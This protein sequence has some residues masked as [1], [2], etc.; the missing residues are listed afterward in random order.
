[1]LSIATGYSVDYLLRQ[2]AAGRENYYTGAVADGEPPGRWWGAGTAALGLS[3]EVDPQDMRAVFERFLDPRDEHFRDPS[4]WGEAATLGHTGRAYT[5]EDELYAQLL[6]R[7]RHA[8]AERRDELRVEAGRKARRN[9]AFL[10]VTFSVQKSVTVLHT[11][12]EAA[13]VR[14]R[15]TG[16]TDAEARWAGYRQAV[17]D[18]I[19][20]GNDAALG[21]LQEQ[22]GYARVGHHGGQGGRWVDAHGWTVAS[23]FQHD[24]RDHDPQLH[25]HNPIVNRVQGPDG[26]W[27]TLDSRAI[28]RM[29]P[30]A[31]AVGERVLS[32]RLAADLGVSMAMRPDG[33][34]REATVVSPTATEMFSSRRRAVSAKAAELISAFEARHG[35]EVNGVERDRLQRQATL[36]SRKAKSHHGESREALLDRVDAQIASEVTGGLAAVAHAYL[37][38]R[39][40]ATEEDGAAAGAAGEVWSAE[41]VLETALAGVQ[42]KKAAWTRAH[43]IREIDAR[44]P[45]HLGLDDPDQISEL[46]DRLSAQGAAMASS[47]DTD[48]PGEDQLPDE[49]R[50]D[51]G[52]SAYRAPGG[53]LFAT[54][55]HV[56]SE[57]TLRAAS[58][59]HGATRL[60]GPAADTLLRH[61]AAQGVA[62]GADQAAAVRGVLTSGAT[63]ETLIGPAGTGKSFTVGALAHAWTTADGGDGSLASRRVVGLATS[64]VAA[65][66][67]ASEGLDA[68]NTARWLATQDRLAAAAGEGRA[69]SGHDQPWRLGRGDLVVVD[70]SSM[71][72]TAA[73]TRIHQHVRAAGAKLL[74]V[75]DH[76]QLAAVG[77]GGAMELIAQTGARYELTDARR[78]TA[79]WEGPA[80]LRLRAGDPTVV[81]NYHRNGRLIDAG[82]LEQAEQSA[83]RAWL[84]DTLAGHRSVLVVDS[85][86]QAARL[87]TQLRHE[88]VRLGR[89]AEHGVPLDRDGTYAGV[90]DTVAARRNGWDLAGRHRNPRGPINRETFTVLDTGDDGSLLV[91]PTGSTRDDGDGGVRLVLPAGYVAADVSLAYAGTVHAV[92]GLSVD[93]S[94]PVITA[95]TSHAAAYVG[96]SRG[97]LNNTAHVATTTAPDDLAHGTEREHTLHRDPRAVL[98]DT[99]ERA[100]AAAAATRAAVATAETLAAEAGSVQTAAERFADAAHLASCERTSG[101]LDHLTAEGHLRPE[102]RAR[103]AAEDGTATLTRLLRAA[104]VAGHQPREVLEAAVVDR[105]LDGAR[106]VTYVIHGRITAAHTF[107]PIGESW[108]EWRPR[109]D[110]PTWDHYLAVLAEAADTR[111]RDLGQQQTKHPERWAV[112]LLGPVPDDPAARADWTQRAGLVAG[113]R[114]ARDHPDQHK[115]IDE[116]DGSREAGSDRGRHGDAVDVL[117]SAPGRG[118]V[119]AHAAYRAAWRAAGL[120][121]HDRDTLELSIGAHRARVQAWEREQTWGPAYVDNLLAGTH[122]AAAQHHQTAQLRYAEAAATPDPDQRQQLETQARDAEALAGHLREEAGRLDEVATAYAAWSAETAMTRALADQSRAYLAA[123]DANSQPAPAVTAAEWLAAEHTARAED[124]PHR[125]ITDTDLTEPTPRHPGDDHSSTTGHAAEPQSSETDQ[126]TDQAQGESAPPGPRDRLEASTADHAPTGGHPER[127]GWDHRAAAD[128]TEAPLPDPGEDHRNGH[129]TD[130]APSERRATADA[131]DPAADAREGDQAGRR[132]EDTVRVP[133]PGETAAELARARRALAE[134]TDRRQQTDQQQYREQQHGTWH[135]DDQ[136]TSNDD[137]RPD[138]A[139]GDP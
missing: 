107:D 13:E 47:L 103:V 84:A 54:P 64:Q 113:Y 17:E 127:D 3:G 70:E 112:E 22:A 138:V 96:L 83:A 51:N 109:L 124:D 32:E 41:A 23:F 49:L 58:R 98:A 61:L 101:W 27:R 48:G 90:G 29:R 34:A 62:L 99:L 35:R 37:T 120:P 25:I 45:D 122:H 18:A 100:E 95:R 69:P 108:A 15:R 16:D 85:N 111:T 129:G 121:E 132:D 5:S 19:W 115:H 131:P 59:D 28:H 67:L 117:G 56:H 86:D 126:N 33:K 128:F 135:S 71:A 43:L 92:E 88:L 68:A 87:S 10:D 136:D 116:A 24:S 97:K 114:E 77:A 74:L 133:E 44:L 6:E 93:T 73:L 53:G 26:Q 66:V 46:L 52:T 130:E 110:D 106:S 65:D 82:T 8:G 14:A 105:P 118:Q 139:E 79:G 76:R 42:A 11:A 80:S 7:E 94:H 2:V 104:E 91:T 36:T 60:S 30:A 63:L 20:A 39:D 75:G 102:E 81:A 1:M 40:Q 9:V 21:Y 78:F 134:I 4:R 38:T 72:D 125:D 119:E 12:F 89:V 55:E 50:L 123:H 137:I 31:A 57:N